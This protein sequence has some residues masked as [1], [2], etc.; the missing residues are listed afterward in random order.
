LAAQT[1]TAIRRTPIANANPKPP[2]LFRSCP[3]L[4]AAKSPFG[5]DIGRN[6]APGQATKKTI[7]GCPKPA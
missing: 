7:V 2:I 1:K 6:R 4:N 5:T 3:R